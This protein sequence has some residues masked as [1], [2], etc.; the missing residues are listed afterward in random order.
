MRSVDSLSRRQRQLQHTSTHSMQLTNPLFATLTRG[1]SRRGR[2]GQRRGW[3]SHGMFKVARSEMH[4]VAVFDSVWV[5]SSPTPSDD[6]HNVWRRF[7]AKHFALQP[8]KMFCFFPLSRAAHADTI[9][10]RIERS[11]AQASS[12]VLARTP[13]NDVYMLTSALLCVKSHCFCFRQV[14]LPRPLNSDSVPSGCGGH[15]TRL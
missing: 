4:C 15:R 9:Q 6:P 3:F 13:T 7:T 8:Y 11:R 10:F 14:F 2:R 1:I 12:L 5:C